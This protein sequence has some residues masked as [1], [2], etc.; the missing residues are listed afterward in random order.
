MSQQPDVPVARM[1]IDDIPLAESDAAFESFCCAHPAH[2]ACQWWEALAQDE[3]DAL[4]KA[5]AE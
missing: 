3:R 4:L 1:Y 2:P 5:A